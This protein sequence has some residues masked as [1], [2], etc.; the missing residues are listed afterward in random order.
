[1]PE[2]GRPYLHPPRGLLREGAPGG[3]GVYT[4]TSTNPNFD[5][6]PCLEHCNG[7]LISFNDDYPGLGLDSHIVFRPQVFGTYN[8]VVSLYRQGTTGGHTVTMTP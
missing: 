8:V 4:I 7:Q 3:G 2:E 1:V 6:Y 5:T